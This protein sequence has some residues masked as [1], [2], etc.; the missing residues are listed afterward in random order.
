MDQLSC[1]TSCAANGAVDGPAER[2]A[3]AAADGALGMKQSA[4]LGSLIDV[5][6]QLSNRREALTVREHRLLEGM[7]YPCPS[8]TREFPLLWVMWLLGE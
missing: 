4:S 6:A 5:G 7:L 1:W 2:F 3:E 8:G